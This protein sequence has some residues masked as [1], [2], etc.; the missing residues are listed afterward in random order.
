MSVVTTHPHSFLQPFFEMEFDTPS[1]P[2]RQQLELEIVEHEA[3]YNVYA[4]MPGHGED[5]V[6]LELN[7]RVLTVTG[8]NQSRKDHPEGA[9]VLRMERSARNFRRSFRLPDDVSE[10]NIS[11]SMD[12]GVLTL[13]LKKRASA[14]P[15]SIAVSGPK[16]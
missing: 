2:R 14:I 9:K 12:K 1:T 13:S 10:D 4:D 5:E 3:E 8:N 11:A 15:R 16:L 6:Q 7:N